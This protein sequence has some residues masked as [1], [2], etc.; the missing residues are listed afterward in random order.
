MYIIYM[1]GNHGTEMHRIKWVR[2]NGAR[3]KERANIF[4]FFFRYFAWE[5]EDID[6]YSACAKASRRRGRCWCSRE[7]GSPHSCS[8]CLGGRCLPECEVR[9]RPHS[10]SFGRGSPVFSFS[11]PVRRWDPSMSHSSCAGRHA[12]GG[13]GSAGSTKTS[14]FQE[15]TEKGS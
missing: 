13:R 15:G 10:G 11:R 8:F 3:I 12:D 2:G 14:R 6:K 9:G 1:G 7:S 5:N 4:L